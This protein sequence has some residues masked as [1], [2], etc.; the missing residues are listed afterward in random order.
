MTINL[1]LDDIM[2]PALADFTPI[3]GTKKSSGGLSTAEVNHNVLA[4][5]TRMRPAAVSENSTTTTIEFDALL[6]IATSGIT[7]QLNSAA[8]IGCRV[9]VIAAEAG[10][11]EY[12]ANGGLSAVT[13][14]A[15]IAK[16]TVATFIWAGTY[17]IANIPFVNNNIMRKVPKNITEYLNDGTFSARIAGTNGFAVMEDIRPGDYIYMSRPITANNPAGGTYAQGGADW[18]QGSQYVTIAGCDTLMGNGD[19][20][21]NTGKIVNYHHVVCVPG[22]GDDASNPQHF[23]R[24]RMNSSNTTANGYAGSEMHSTVLGAVVTSKPS[25]AGNTDSINKQL[26]YE[27]DSHLKATRE[28]LTNAMTASLYNRYG[29]AGGAA[30]GWAWYDCQAVL[31]SEVECYGSIVWSS[32]GF[33]TGNANHWLPLFQQSN[34]ARNNRTAYYWLKDVVS[35]AYFAYANGNGGGSYYGASSAGRFV[36]PRFVLA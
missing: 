9:R 17:W 15:S 16:G 31:M 33:D 22:K 24:S 34:I 6:A 8:Y 23:G 11:V 29:S 21:D 14:T 25:S 10:N 26:K 7:I 5:F 2:I 36:R 30:S 13:R 18:I 20:N 4:A 3:F 32:S 1:K 28:L 19:T 12:T 27:F 35:S